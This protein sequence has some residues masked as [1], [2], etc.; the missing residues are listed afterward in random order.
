MTFTKIF[1]DIIF[2]M[3]YPTFNK[4]K[5]R[6]GNFRFVLEECSDHVVFNFQ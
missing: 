2:L 4:R 3:A 5:L 1:A 6:Q